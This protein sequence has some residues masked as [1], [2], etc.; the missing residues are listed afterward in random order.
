MEA[1]KIYKK[2]I[3]VVN[4]IQKLQNV[5]KLKII[6]LT[7]D[8]SKFFNLIEK[9]FIYLNKNEV[10]KR[11]S[12]VSSNVRLTMKINNS[13]EGLNI[14]N[15]QNYYSKVKKEGENANEVDKRLI[16]LIDLNLN[17]TNN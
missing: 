17:L 8:Q 5:D 1:F 3:D 12:Q 11:E 14:V 4:I 16:K 6:L 10:F 15:F 9:P 2:E 13:K 7:D